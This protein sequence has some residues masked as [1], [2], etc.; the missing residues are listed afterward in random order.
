[1]RPHT[2]Y[3][4]ISRDPKVIMVRL[5]FL[6]DPGLSSNKGVSFGGHMTVQFAIN[7]DN[8]VWMRRKITYREYR[9][10]NNPELV[11]HLQWSLILSE[12]ERSGDELSEAYNKSIIN[13]RVRMSIRWEPKF[14]DTQIRSAN[15]SLK[16]VKRFW[17]R[18][19]LAVHYEPHRERFL[20]ISHVTD[21][22]PTW[23]L[24]KCLDQFLPLDGQQSL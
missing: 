22:L 4:I 24:K 2:V 6:C 10:L 11:D 8:P 5:P 16:K 3:S 21:P 14:L 17:C 15:K 13:H 1:M 9:G 7:M 23:L 19:S 12:C 18:T 20:R